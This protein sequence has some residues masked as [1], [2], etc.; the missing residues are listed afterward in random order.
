M[1]SVVT[2]AEHQ[3]A[4]STDED[5]SLPH[6]TTILKQLV[7]TW[8]GTKRIVCAHSLFASVISAV[9]QQRT[10]LPFIGVVQMATRG[11][12]MGVISAIPLY[13][14]RQRS[15]YMHVTAHGETDLMAVV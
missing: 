15:C 10:G 13:S 2:T 12:P 7:T 8:A 3:W 1:L 4:T 5:D 6:G 9:Q 11:Y 14:R